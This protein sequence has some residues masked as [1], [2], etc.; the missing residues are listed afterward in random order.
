[1]MDILVVEDE[2]LLAMALEDCLTR[3]GHRVVGLARSRAEALECA[4]RAH[5]DLAL[6]DIRLAGGENGV[7]IAAE[8]E[9]RMSVPVL[10]ASGQVHEAE[11][12]GVGMGVLRKPYSEA[13][14]LRSLEVVR[15]LREGGTPEPVP[16][17]LTLFEQPA[18]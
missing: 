4:A 11:E 9:E 7:E 15:R 14:V 10:Y 16:S 6:L 2:F 3:A 5:P 13:D 18:A 12:S 1:M 8:L 17:N